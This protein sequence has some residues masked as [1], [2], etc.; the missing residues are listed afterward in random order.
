MEIK[1][2]KFDLKRAKKILNFLAGDQ[3]PFAPITGQIKNIDPDPGL[4]PH[5]EPAPARWLYF[6][7]NQ[8][9]YIENI[10]LKSLVEVKSESEVSALLKKYK[11]AE[12]MKVTAVFLSDAKQILPEALKSYP[13]LKIIT[14]MDAVAL[15]NQVY[16]ATLVRIDPKKLSNSEL[17]AFMK[18]S[19]SK[20]VDVFM[21][22][23]EK[24]NK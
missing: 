14:V 5:K 17:V 9:T 19:L 16:A 24:G 7:V 10:K 2:E 23:V 4:E 21:K 15:S 12:E 22:Q 13:D 6:F 20:K 1:N 8:F 18:M 3:Q 11:T